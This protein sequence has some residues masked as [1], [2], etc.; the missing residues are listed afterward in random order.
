MTASMQLFDGRVAVVG[1]GVMGEAVVRGWID[2]GA[3]AADRFT[4]VEPSPERREQLTASLGEVRAVPTGEDAFPAE[5]VVLAVKPQV[6]DAVAAQLSPMLGGSLVVSIAAG[7]STARLES[8]LPAGTRVVRVMPNT[9]AMVG[10]GMAVVSGGGE[11]SEEDVESVRA[12]FD[13][14]GQAI[15]L[16]EKYQNAAT[17]VSGS[18]PAYFALIVDGLARAG[19]AAGLTRSVAQALAVQTML[20]TATMLQSTGMHPEALV[21]SVASPGGTT[22]A[23]IGALEAGGVRTALAEAVKAAVA[24]AEELG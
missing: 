17:A 23:A 18:G 2:A 24:R 22:I 19:V 16:E 4:I 6:I 7:A 15:T 13:V 1:G 20:G 21:D 8:L 5:L 9:P 14:L 3:V 11:A 10:A 12:L